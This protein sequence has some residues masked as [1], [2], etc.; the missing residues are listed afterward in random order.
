MLSVA[1]IKSTATTNPYN[2]PRKVYV[3]ASMEPSQYTRDGVEKEVQHFMVCDHTGYIKL[4]SFD[5]SKAEA[6]KE[7]TTVIIKN[8]ITKPEN[9]IVTAK[10]QVFQAP[11]MTVSQTIVTE[12]RSILRPPTPPPVDIPTI[13]S[14]PVKTLQSLAGKIIQVSY[15]IRFLIPCRA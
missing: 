14:S 12:A 7:G 13:K 9:I 1:N 6:I 4:T 10:A 3:V 11:P 8:Y 15:I 2:L 5:K